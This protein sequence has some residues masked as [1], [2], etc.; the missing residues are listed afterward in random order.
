MIRGLSP[1]PGSWTTLKNGDKEI[2]VKILKASLSSR[3]RFSE[4]SIGKVLIN[5]N[6]IHIYTKDGVIN[7]T[8]IQIENK[9]EM[10]AKDLLNGYKFYDN[11]IVY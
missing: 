2:R 3:R 5:H 9:K 6:Q 7:C 4:S 11:S 8:K 1:R 10:L